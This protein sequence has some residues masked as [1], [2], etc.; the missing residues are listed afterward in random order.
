MNKINCPESQ[1]AYALQKQ[2][3]TILQQVKS[4]L[5][6]IPEEVKKLKQILSR[7]IDHNGIKERCSVVLSC[8][9]MDSIS[10]I[11]KIHSKP[12][13]YVKRWLER[14]LDGGILGLN[15]SPRSGRPNSLSA[16]SIEKINEIC[17]TSPDYIR[18]HENYTY[19]KDS[20]Q[21]SDIWT[22]KSLAAVFKV[23]TATMYRFCSKNNISRYASG[24]YCFSTDRDYETKITNVHNALCNGSDDKND[25]VLSFDEKPCIQA[26]EHYIV[27]THDGSYKKGC[28][29]VRHGTIH[30]LA[31]FNPLTGKVY[32]RF[33]NKKDR[34]EVKNF[35][36]VMV[37]NNPELQGKKIKLILDNLKTHDID[38]VW[39]KEHPEFEFVFTPTTSS[40]CNPIEAHFSIYSNSVLKGASWQSVDELVEASNKWYRSY[41]DNPIPFNIDFD[42]EKHIGSRIK[43]IENMKKKFDAI[44]ER[45]KNGLRLNNTGYCYYYTIGLYL[46]RLT[47]EKATNSKAVKEYKAE[48]RSILRQ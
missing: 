30:L 3:S 21:S 5:I 34:E 32:H 19:A 14:F 36:E 48:L 10:K 2:Q 42:L 24:S 37:K 8:L 31:A 33:T 41:N 38:S 13:Q 7:R 29:Y 39:H 28:R 44:V 11:A 18:S 1:A 20:I 26:N 6:E 4:H 17:L 43:T 25:V 15:D 47:D 23:S 16:N 35:L 22:F 45:C 46:F 40:W 9:E 27:P 12:R